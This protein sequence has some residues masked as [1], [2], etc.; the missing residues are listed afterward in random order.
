MDDQQTRAF[1]VAT[2]AEIEVLRQAIAALLAMTLKPLPFERRKAFLDEFG[3]EAGELPADYSAHN[4]EVTAFYEE[5][6]AA[7]PERAA[8]LVNAVRLLLE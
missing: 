5:V 7:M 4:L 8:M 1:A 3:R 2:T 6:A